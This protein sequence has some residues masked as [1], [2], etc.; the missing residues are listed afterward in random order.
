MSAGTE[1]KKQEIFRTKD[2]ASLQGKLD[3]CWE[4]EMLVTTASFVKGELIVIFSK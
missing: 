1:I 4:K 3:E 2:Y